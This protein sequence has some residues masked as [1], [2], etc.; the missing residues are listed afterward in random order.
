MSILSLLIS[1]RGRMVKEAGLE[2]KIEIDLG[3]IISGI[4]VITDVVLI[5][6]TTAIKII[7]LG[8]TATIVGILGISIVSIVK[9]LVG[10]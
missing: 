5:Y 6:I 10:L 4:T 2:S 9:I 8:I 7:D 1:A 3:A